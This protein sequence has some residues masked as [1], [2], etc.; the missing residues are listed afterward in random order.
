MQP[1]M[2]DDED[3]I[4]SEPVRMGLYVVLGAVLTVVGLIGIGIYAFTPR[5]TPVEGDGPADA[6]WQSAVILGAAVCT[7]VGVLLLLLALVASMHARRAQREHLE[8]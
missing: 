8:H 4:R 5:N 1:E 6:A 7:G 2:R 3:P